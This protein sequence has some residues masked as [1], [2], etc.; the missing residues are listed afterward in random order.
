MF[1]GLGLHPVWRKA[2]FVRMLFGVNVTF[3]PQHFL[4]ITGMPRRYI[5][6][7]DRII[8]YNSLSRFGSI[9]SL[10]RLYHFLFILFEGFLARRGLVFWCVPNTEVE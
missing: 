6:Y 10:M 4:G 8:G 9:C 7:P 1:T 3:F 2:Q 5:D